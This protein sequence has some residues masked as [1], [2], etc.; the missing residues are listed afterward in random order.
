MTESRDSFGTEAEIE[1]DGEQAVFFSLPKLARRLDIDMAKLPITVRLLLENQLRNEDGELVTRAH[2]ESLAA[3]QP[4]GQEK[5]D[6]AFLPARVLMQDFTG[7]PSVVDLAAMRDAMDEM[8]GDPHRINPRIP[9]DLVIDHSVQVDRF[10]TLDALSVNA[11]HELERNR[12]RY[13]FLKWGQQNLENFNV[14]PPA[15]GICHQVNLEYLASVVLVKKA[16][17]KTIV[18]PDTVLGLDSHTTMINGIGVL[19]WGV[20]GIEAEAVMLGQPYYLLTPEVIGIEVTGRMPEHATATDLVLT[21]TKMMREKGVVGKFI[22]FF[23]EGLDALTLPDRATIANMTPE[24]GATA[25]LFPVDSRTLD[26]LLFT[27]RTTAHVRRIEQYLSA[28]GL[29]YSSD[30]EPPVFTDT[31][32]LDLGGIEASV[33]GPIRPQ[34][35]LSL[36]RLKA[37]FAEKFVEIFERD[38]SGEP[39]ID[40]WEQEGGAVEWPGERAEKFV[41]R[42]AAGDAG[43][44]VNRPYES[45]YLEHGSVVIAAITSCTNTSNPG[46]L[47]GA[48]LLAKNA[49]ERGLRVRPWVKTSF[50]PGSKVVVDYL[51]A[52]GLM[53][54]LQALGFH[55][56]AFG[57]TTCIGNS[58]PLHRDVARVVEET[59]LV[60]ASVLS[61]NRNFEGRINP[62]TRANYLASPLLVVAFALAGTVNI[63]METEPLRHDSNADPVYLKDIWPTRRQIDDAMAFVNRD[64][65]LSQYADV[66]KG[67]EN[68]QDLPVP[69]GQRC[70][71]DRNS[72]YIQ[73]PPFFRGMPREMPAVEDV[74]GARVLA[75]LGDAVTTDHISPAGSIPEDSPA[76]RFLL[77]QGVKKADFNSYGSRRGNHTV[78]VRGTF[79]NIRLENFLVPGRKG[80][81]TR[82]MPDG[83]EMTIFDAAEQYREQGVPLVVIAGKAY[84]S[85][86]SRDWAAKGTLLLGVRAVIAE[87][88]ERI[89]RSNLVAMGV[90]PLEFKEGEG[91]AVLGLTGR[92]SFYLEG[93]Y[94]ALSP[95]KYLAVKAVDNEGTEK[96]FTVRVRLDSKIEVEYYRHGGILHYV[97]RRMLTTS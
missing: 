7:V 80:G 15:T 60:V 94:K 76:G 86:S 59:G 10:G 95:G 73:A 71:W 28:Q 96:I 48:G 5:K 50:A 85:G 19:G 54:Y 90:L 34:Q 36:S 68:W 88:F 26:Y 53:P 69:G 1:L 2:I 17:R 30:M 6:V 23:G 8:G 75:L 13:A 38:P 64:M 84:G 11:A 37:D 56:V 67:D 40:G 3:W 52:A 39:K 78:M 97:I 45:F 27:G 31:V 72:T 47:L 46:V 57:C 62:L 65:F 12:E 89:H 14:V 93:L 55:V 87:S 92:E 20:G 21:I 63:N 82:F 70:R 41:H 33:A 42:K 74:I 29:F 4:A 25:T 16:G 44:S 43:V 49:V 77:S 32:R 83:D 81:W 66:F 9:V 22:E 51:E 58:G 35:R 91:A 18:F 79:A 24:F 61:G